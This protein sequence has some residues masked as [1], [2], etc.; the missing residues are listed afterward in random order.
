MRSS[1]R[2]ILFAGQKFDCTLF[3][4]RIGRSTTNDLSCVMLS[5]HGLRSAWP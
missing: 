5:V 4:S 3:L 1:S 2:C